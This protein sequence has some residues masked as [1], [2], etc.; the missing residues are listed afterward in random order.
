MTGHVRSLDVPRLIFISFQAFS[1][2]YD[3]VLLSDGAG[4]TSPSSSQESIEFNCAKTWGFCVSCKEF[5][6]GLGLQEN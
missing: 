1:K 4:T 6:E 3:V 2:G 5:A